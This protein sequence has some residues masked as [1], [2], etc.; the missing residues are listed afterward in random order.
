LAGRSDDLLRKC[1]SECD[2]VRPLR[3]KPEIV[4]IE[5]VVTK[6]QPLDKK[7]QLSNL[8]KKKKKFLIVIRNTNE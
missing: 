1:F 2:H 3:H 4:V 5:N 8:F 7:C 6:T